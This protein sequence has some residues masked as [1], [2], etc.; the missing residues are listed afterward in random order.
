MP[1]PSRSSR[2]SSSV[3]PS[4]GSNAS[5]SYTSS[6]PYA[7]RYAYQTHTSPTSLFDSQ[8]S[9]AVLTPRSFDASI[10]SISS[11]PGV[12]YSVHD[13][14]M[15]YDPS[16]HLSLNSQSVPPFDK[17]NVIHPVYNSK[18]SEIRIDIHPKIDKGF[19]KADQDWTCYR[20][21][22]FSVAC[23]Y[24]LQPSLDP[25]TEPLYLHRSSTTA[26]ERIQAFAICI[27][28]RVNGDEGKVIELVQHTPKRDKG[29]TSA[30]E[31]VKLLP[32]MPG[33]L[34]YAESP[35]SLSPASQLSPD[36]DGVY[37]PQREQ[38]PRLATFDRIQF[39]N[40]TA[41]NGKRRA[42]QQYFN[43]VAEIFAQLPSSQSSEGQWVKIATK[44]SARMVVRGRS[45][46]HYS[47]DRR[48]S[49]TSMGGPG[50]GGTSGDGNG[51]GNRD[52]N[53]TGASGSR[54]SAPGMGFSGTSRAG[55]GSYLSHH[56]S[57]RHSPSEGSPSY[58]S[59]SSGYRNGTHVVRRHL[60]EPVLTREEA[61]AIEDYEGYQYYPA[62]LYDIS[63]HESH[64]QH[65]KLPLVNADSVAKTDRHQ[66][67]ATP[68]SS[69]SRV[70]SPPVI[71]APTSAP[72]S[73]LKSEVHS[74]AGREATNY[75]YSLPS[76]P[77]VSRSSNGTPNG[78]PGCGRFQGVSTSRGYYPEAPPL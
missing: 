20:R 61:S 36:Y 17:T 10:S 31:K 14:S 6:A 27:T 59:T 22:Y 78:G 73:Y 15:H 48:N 60:E 76:Q 45:P 39:K 5:E 3:L 11:P 34:G 66:A 71:Y 72:K 62:P 35:A 30:P 52:P 44:M 12:A 19:F 43:L 46:G 40:A 23:H 29:P 28:A 77:N 25:A 32:H 1:P 65:R 2:D 16:A 54:S 9:S 41:N 63:P 38:N 67:S 70:S 49:S 24:T 4:L 37:P 64:A 69:F 57:M 53:L 13:A 51:G 26:H 75:Q 55:S 8:P 74:D 18:G 50:N 33:L 21:N 42:A 47:D 56:A 7:T 68:R 58:S